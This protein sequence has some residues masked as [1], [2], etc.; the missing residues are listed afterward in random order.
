MTYELPTLPYAYDALE[1]HYDEQTLRLHHTKHHQGYVNGLNAATAALAA[2]REAGDFG[3][4]KNLTGALAF[5]GAGHMLHSAFWTNM[6]PQ[7]G[8][9]PAGDL[10]ARIEQDFGSFD[11]FLGQFKKAAATVEGSGWGL[12]VWNSALGRLE[13]LQAHNHQNTAHWNATVLLAVD[14]WEHAYYLKYQNRRAEFI[15]VFF[16]S[17]V[18]W[19]DVAARFAAAK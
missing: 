15:D 5:H 19:D 3:A 17:L 9:A 4:T 1:P 16:A 2:A 14:V 8:G 7:G 10:L 6:K 13:I 18:N 12:L 11:A